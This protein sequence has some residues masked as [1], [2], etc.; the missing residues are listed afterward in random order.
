M[1]ETGE[2]YKE[3]QKKCGQRISLR[4][5]EYIEY[6]TR[7]FTS[8]DFKKGGIDFGLNKIMHFCLLLQMLPIKK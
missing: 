2:K 5:E 7:P 8:F 4:G 6:K 3:S 1:I